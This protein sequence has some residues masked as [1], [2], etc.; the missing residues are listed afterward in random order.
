MVL[1]AA[2]SMK[3][4]VLTAP[5]QLAL[6]DVP[7][8]DPGPGQV[9]IRIR[10][11][12][13]CGT[14]LKIYQGSVKVHHP[15]IMGHEMAGEVI[16]GGD[17]CVLPKTRVVVDPV[18]YCGTCETC[19]A[20]LTNLCPNGM[21]LGRDADGGFAECALVPCNH[22]FPLPD[23]IPDPIAPVIQVVTT[24]VHAHRQLSMFPGQSV[25]VIGLGV[26]GQIHLQLSKLRGA[27]PVIGITRS[28]WKQRLAEQ[29]GASETFDAGAQGIRDVLETT[30]GRGADIVIESTGS[31]SALADAVSMA[32]PGGTLLWFGITTSE[33]ALPLYQLYFKE[34]RV[35]NARAAKSEDFQR[36][37]DL[38]AR[39]QLKLDPLLADILPLAQLHNAFAMLQT[40]GGRHMK[41]VIE[42]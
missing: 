28:K 4:A 23:N 37:I 34:L 7:G 42:T 30:R 35:V 26:T 11:G 6:R 8:L 36:S 33:S 1:V 12:G 17:G 13:V 5:H 2:N 39:G 10:H 20:G 32:S 3:A 31:P 25:A 21:L 16:A 40:N 27:D 41:I 29:L 24:C 9:L 14:D 18:L 15:L 19:R 38:V 22:V